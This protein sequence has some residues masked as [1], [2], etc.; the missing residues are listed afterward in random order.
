MHLL[1]IAI[2]YAPEQTG[3]VPHTQALCEHLV[4]RGHRVSV[5]TARPHQPSWRVFDG[6][7]RRLL[8]RECVD[9]VDVW[10]VA[11]YVPTRPRGLL[12]RLTYDTSFAAAGFAASLLVHR[13]DAVLYIGA[14]PE[15][16]AVAALAAK[17]RHVPFLAK[18]TDLAANIGESLGIV[19]NRGLAELFRRFEYGTYAQAGKVLVLCQGFADELAR[20]GVPEAR[21]QVVY[22]SEDLDQLRPGASGEWFRRQH[23]FASDDFLVLHMGSL[24]LKQ[25]LDTAL[26][27]AARIPAV[28]GIRWVY[29]GGGPELQRLKALAAE[30]GVEDRTR[31]LDLQPAE[32]LS[33]VLASGGACLLSQRASVTDAVIPGKLITYMAGGRPVVAS[34]T[35]ESES[36]KLINEAKCGLLAHPENADALAQAVRLLRHDPAW[37]ESLGANA[38]AYAE[39]HFAR[40]VVLDAQES[41][42]W[43]L[44]ATRR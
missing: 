15:V 12:A 27:A 30:L 8:T 40:H 20:F 28:E 39:A 25:G 32:R 18:V 36:G 4:K 11:N 24:G 23:G 29:I 17:M 38:R 16:A 26:Q 44:L 5:I 14:Q 41:A 33:E 2:N 34:V 6:Y 42:L 43:E 19:P 7:R 22:N 10:H 1:V 35:A 9:G 31:F 37:A 21:L 3:I 13:V